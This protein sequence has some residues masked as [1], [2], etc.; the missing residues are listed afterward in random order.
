MLLYLSK[1]NE[2]DISVNIYY[3]E[4]GGIIQDNKSPVLFDPAFH[5]PGEYSSI[6]QSTLISDNRRSGA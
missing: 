3:T 6:Q 4:C 1:Y 2:I 5:R